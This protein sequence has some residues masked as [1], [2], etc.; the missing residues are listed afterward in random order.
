MAVHERVGIG[1]QRDHGRFELCAGAVATVLGPCDPPTVRGDAEQTRETHW[2][3][4]FV[5]AVVELDKFASANHV[6]GI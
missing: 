6:D 1:H 5:G 2:S 3:I 4:S